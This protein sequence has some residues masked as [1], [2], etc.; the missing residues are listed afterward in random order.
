MMNY[1][2]GN[3]HFDIRTTAGDTTPMQIGVESCRAGQFL[4]PIGS[5]ATS[6]FWF[7]HDGQ[8]HSMTMPLNRF[9]NVDFKTVNQF[10]Q[11]TSVGDVASGFNLS[12]DNVWWEP[13]VA[14]VTPQNGNFGVYT[15][16]ASH[17]NAGSFT[18][19]VQGN[20]FV[21]SQTMTPAT[22]HPYE[23]TQDISLVSAPGL[24]W[25]G[26]AFTPNVK[27]N[28]TAFQYAGC[29]LEFAMKTTS[30]GP[31]MVGMQSGDINGMGQK[32]ITFWGPGSDPYGF[33]RDGQWHVVD[34]PMAAFGP[35]VDLSAVSQFFEILSTTAPVSNIELDDIHFTN[36]GVAAAPDQ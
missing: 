15:E 17:E 31:F 18:L 19:G 35:E 9:A 24:T 10:F 16:T 21:W 33:V 7:P 8:W 12:I 20:F 13:S 26:M 6:E 29:N 30:T 4:L 22:Q 14:R 34:I 11:I 2:D 23:G 5:D 28:L 25:S 1:S 3:L 32:W 27:Y 36:G